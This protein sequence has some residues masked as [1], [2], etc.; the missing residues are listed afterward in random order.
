MELEKNNQKEMYPHHYSIYGFLPSADCFG[1]LYDV[2]NVESQLQELILDLAMIII[3][4]P[5]A[6]KITNTGTGQRSTG[7]GTSSGTGSPILDNSL[8]SSCL[9]S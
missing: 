9:T 6:Q 3:W 7:T 2:A 5:N 1:L 4:Y 8:V